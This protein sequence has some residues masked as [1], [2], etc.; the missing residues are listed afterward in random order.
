MEAELWRTSYDVV[1]KWFTGGDC[2]RG[3]GILDAAH[4]CEALIDVACRP[5]WNDPDML[6]VGLNGQSHHG[7]GCTE[8]EYRSQFSL[9]CLLSAPL[10][11]G[12]DIRTMDTFT[13]ETLLNPELIAVNQDSLGV[14][15]WRVK[16]MT[17]YEI[18]KKPMKNGDVV[19]GFLNLGDTTKSF[20]VSFR[21]LLIK[22]TYRVRDLWAGK[23][24]GIFDQHVSLE[25]QSHETRVLRF[26]SITP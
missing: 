12:N 1:D 22:G 5:G 7:G 25:V 24:L 8:A 10:L 2:N 11:A 19:I 3:I 18:W 6:I 26:F 23:E 15:A 16:K 20:N 4:Q 17:G 14:P 9:W 13:K 21:D